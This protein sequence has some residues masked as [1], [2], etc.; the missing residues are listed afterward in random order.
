[1]K[2]LLHEQ[3][4]NFKILFRNISS[5][6]LLIIGP[7]AL[8]L[9]I[10]FAYS[11]EGIHSVNIGAISNDFETLEPAFANFSSF[12]EIIQYNNVESCVKDMAL[13]KVHICLEFGKDFMQN[14]GDI[15]T[16]TIVFYYDNSKKALSTKIVDSISEFFGVQA[17]KISLDS[18]TTIFQNIEN[19]VVYLYDRNADISTIVN[20]SLSIKHDLILRKEKLIEVQEEFTPTY[21]NIKKIQQNLDDMNKD[22][23]TSY[24]EF[25]DSLDVVETNLELVK[26]QLLLLKIFFPSTK[27]YI[28][29]TTYTTNLS[30]FTDNNITY[31][32]LDDLNYS[33]INK[34][35]S[36]PE[37][38]RSIELNELSEDISTGFIINA[39]LDSIKVFE[40]SLL[41]LHNNIDTYFFYIE[42]QKTEF[43]KA[44]DLLDTIDELL[45]ADIRTSDE[46]IQ[47]I[48]SAVQKMIVVQKELNSSL[49]ELSKLD[50]ELAQ[51]LVNPIMENYEPLLPGLENIKIAFPSMLAII[52]IFISIL[53]ANIV[54][55]SELNSKAFY[56]NLI[57]PVKKFIFTGGL[58][59][60]NIF[61]VFF[62]VAILLLV[63]HFSFKIDVVTH[64]GSLL[65]VVFVLVLLYTCLGMIF[66]ILIR[67]EQ[68]SILTTT[69]VALA[70]FLF[71]D[72]VTPL[73]TMPKLAA[74]IAAKNPQ[75][76]ASLA[77]RKILIFGVP[78]IGTEL[79]WLI[80]YLVI[81]FALVIY[82]TKKKIK[83]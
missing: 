14:S 42:K 35:I 83:N 59:I 20:E 55:L 70:F 1:M 79:L 23:N 37:F 45:E 64:L 60:T 30:F 57:A 58:M 46:Y 33:V 24:E 50:P 69:F 29:N 61:V 63:A 7:L 51:Q 71:S 52:I 62:Q 67:N 28:S 75:V 68:S 15:P 6:L 76:L 19:M 48:D 77:F 41:A 16:G 40:D 65:I 43:D 78:V 10:G 56:R 72:Q 74:L 82:L 27:I 18:A 11:G 80:G 34:S 3:I 9:L 25:N 81:A 21:N 38:N 53:F 17:D 5:L 2:K 47:K 36:I 49:K 8:I 22:I 73:E 26:S 54:T 32:D 66:A 44:V 12:A 39:A 13:E 4:K 31:F